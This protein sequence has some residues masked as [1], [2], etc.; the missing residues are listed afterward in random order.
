M[1]DQEMVSTEWHLNTEKKSESSILI[2][3]R[4]RVV[5]EAD[6]QIGGRHKRS[7][8]VQYV[9]VIL[10]NVP[11]RTTFKDVYI[12][13][14]LLTYQGPNQ[15]PAAVVLAKSP[16]ANFSHWYLSATWP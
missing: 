10:A 1:F 7:G 5:R 2:P 4:R 13:K 3:I 11:E 16:K 15:I 12:R 6:I 9:P 8:Y 14:A